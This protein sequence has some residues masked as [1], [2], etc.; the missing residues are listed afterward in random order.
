MKRQLFD[1]IDA[2]IGRDRPART[3]DFKNMPVL[4]A[5]VNETLR[6]Y[7]AAPSGVS[8]VA[9][10]DLEVCDGKYLIPTGTILSVNIWGL[11]HDPQH[12][13]DPLEWKPQRWI[14]N[15]D[16]RKCNNFHPFQLGPRI[17]LGRFLSLAEMKAILVAFF[18][19]FD[20]VASTPSGTVELVESDYAVLNKPQKPYT[21][22]V[23]RR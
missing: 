10:E 6:R 7:P 22:D 18:Q 9:D 15:P 2:V 17:C 4:D 8:H 23:L 13:P 16:L 5:I 11:H 21:L 14:D 3:D 19:R 1:E 12:F 20:L